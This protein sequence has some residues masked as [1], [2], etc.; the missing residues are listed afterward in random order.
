MFRELASNLLHCPLRGRDWAGRTEHIAMESAMNGIFHSIKQIL[1]NKSGE[2]YLNQITGGSGDY[3]ARAVAGQQQW[4]EA[5]T[6]SPAMPPRPTP[7]APGPTHMDLVEEASEESFPA[8]DAP[9][10]T[11]VTSLGAPAHSGEAPKL[12]EGPL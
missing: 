7:P 9:G 8:S 2:E 1:L 3:W 11:P 4:T 6:A 5:P 12:T 10:W